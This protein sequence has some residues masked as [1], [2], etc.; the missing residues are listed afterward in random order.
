MR[1]RAGA[2]GK[3]G[4]PVVAGKLDGARTQV[5]RDGDDVVI[6]SRSL[7]DLTARLPEVVAAARALPARR[8]IL[9]GEAIA[10]RADGRPEPFQVTSSRIASGAPGVVPVF[11]DILALDDE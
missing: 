9:D 5:H 1:G 7:D 2:R 8:F 10:L 3:S 4:R 11:F 6:A